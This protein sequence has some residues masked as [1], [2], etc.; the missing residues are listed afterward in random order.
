MRFEIAI[1]L[2]YCAP[3]AIAGV[4]IVFVAR[5]RR[6]ASCDGVSCN[7]AARLDACA[8]RNDDGSRNPRGA[9]RGRMVRP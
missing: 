3:L 7:C 9:G 1:A 6:L 4:I 8:C 2:V 5:R